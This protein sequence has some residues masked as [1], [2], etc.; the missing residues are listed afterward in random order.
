MPE[1][2]R[3]QI[4]VLVFMVHETHFY[5]HY[6]NKKTTKNVQFSVVFAL[7][8]DLQRRKRLFVTPL[9][10]LIINIISLSLVHLH[11]ILHRIFCSFLLFYVGFAVANIRKSMHLILMKQ[12]SFIKLFNKIQ[13]FLVSFRK[14]TPSFLQ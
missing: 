13:F 11:R 4:I 1:L 9:N 3:K 10:S 8:V 2:C 7:F 14:F 5:R 12:V 6:F